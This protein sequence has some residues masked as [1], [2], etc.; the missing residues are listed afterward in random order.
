[1]VELGEKRGEIE[2]DRPIKSDSWRRGDHKYHLSKTVIDVGS[3]SAYPFSCILSHLRTQFPP[4]GLNWFAQIIIPHF[5]PR[6]V[7]S[8]LPINYSYYTYYC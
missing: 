7:E 5:P 1:M 3:F 6:F 8:W 4:R 2:K